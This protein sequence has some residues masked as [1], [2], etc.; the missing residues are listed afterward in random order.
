[1][2]SILLAETLTLRDAQVLTARMWYSYDPNP[3]GLTQ[4]LVISTIAL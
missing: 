3:D 2:S 1:M 4:R